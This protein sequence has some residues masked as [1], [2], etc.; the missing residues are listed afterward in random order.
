MTREDFKY[1]YSTDELFKKRID[2]KYGKYFSELILSLVERRQKLKMT[3]LDLAYTSDVSLGTIANIEN[4]KQI[5][6]YQTLNK[7]ANVLGVDIEIKV[8]AIE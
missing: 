3:T 2:E 7:I 4:F 1:K 8:T 5:P 6:T